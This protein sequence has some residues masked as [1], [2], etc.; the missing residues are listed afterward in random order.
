MVCSE[1]PYRL[2]QGF[3]AFPLQAMSGA[4]STELQK[5]EHPEETNPPQLCLNPLQHQK[6]PYMIEN[7]NQVFKGSQ[8]LTSGSVKSFLLGLG[9]SSLPAVEKARCNLHAGST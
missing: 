9:T 4:D 5:A 7:A 8:E 3:K 6:G 2:V 1:H